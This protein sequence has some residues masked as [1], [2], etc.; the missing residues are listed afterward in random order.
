LPL[1]SAL[2]GMKAK[3]I[4]PGTRGW[5]AIGDTSNDRQRRTAS[6]CTTRLKPFLSGSR[7]FGHC[8]FVRHRKRWPRADARQCS[9]ARRLLRCMS[10]VLALMRPHAM[11]AIPPLLEH[12]RM[13]RGDRECD[14]HDPQ[15]SFDGAAFAFAYRD[16]W[17]V[18]GW[19]TRP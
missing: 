5:Q 17:N 13:S 7:L 11:S 4:V 12:K 1:M 9:R 3:A 8:L 16:I 15:R 10:Q 2:R 14:V 18:R 6:R 19:I